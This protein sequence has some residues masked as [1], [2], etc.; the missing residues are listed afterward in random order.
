MSTPNSPA[1]SPRPSSLT[2]SQSMPVPGAAMDVWLP[3]AN[4]APLPIR[5]TS[6]PASADGMG[7]L[8]A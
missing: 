1:L 6:A 4:G 5:P 7:A 8:A 2:A 3:I